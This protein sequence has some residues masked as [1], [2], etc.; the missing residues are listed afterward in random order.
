M[1]VAT[2]LTRPFSISRWRLATR[3]R[4]ERPS[5]KRKGAV[6]TAG[7]V[8]T[9]ALLLAAC[10]YVRFLGVSRYLWDNPTHDRNAHYLYSLK[11]ATDVR[12][13]QVL[14]LL[15]DLNE[16]RVW[17]PLHGVLAG[18]VLLAGGRDYRLA[19]LPSLAGWVLT[20]LFGFLVARRA[21]GRGGTLAGLIAALFIAAS[22]AHRAFATD[23]M[24]ESLG[25]AL[26]LVVLY[27]YLL[28]V[29]GQEDER[30]KGRCLGLALS[31]LFL[32]KYNYWLLVGLALAA[33]EFTARPRYFVQWAGD[34]LGSVPWRRWASAQLRHPLTYALAAVLLL[35]GVVSWHGDQPFTWGELRI[36]LYPPHNLLHLAY[37]LVF[38]RLTAWWWQTGR[39]RVRRLDDRVRQV[40][41]WH[42]CPLAVWFL[43]PKHPSYFLWYLSLAN[44]APEQP[45]D[46]LRGI[47]QYGAWLIE[48]YHCD[49]KW[50]MLSLG[51]CAA[52]L[53][54]WR[55]V[56]PGGRAVLLFVIIAAG[57]A[58]AHPNQKSRNLHSWMAA[59]WVMAG[60]GAAT[61]LY[62][63]RWPRLASW[64]GGALVTVLAGM[65]LPALLAAGHS[66][67]GGLHPASFSM[68]DA[69]D[70]YLP[71]LDHSRR[72]L[73]LTS[74]PLK[75]LAQWTF[76][77][78]YGRFA[79]LEEYWYGFGAPGEENR[80]G[81][82]QWLRT[83]DCETLVYCD[84]IASRDWA[85][86]GPECELH[87]ELRD[88][89][90]TQRA[91]RLIRQTDFPA[92]ACRI[93][94]WRR[95]P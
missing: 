49:P 84:R 65:Q 59:V 92:Y 93:Q 5:P 60:M 47:R 90:R 77:E 73:I 50:A 26:S 21:V 82:E 46:L 78:R 51:M 81:F 62:H 72:T 7:I 48:D 29:Q 32:E 57:L 83:T 23:I 39:R 53:M 25:A 11:L 6:W 55:R 89:V 18:A 44:A 66:P 79:G 20:V 35:V 80:R 68:L 12:N 8:F 28:A 14:Q 86:A 9:V 52:G 24:L 41:L 36:S 37:V 17:P 40:V 42:V 27:T 91:F 69:I 67:E 87:A 38:V 56:R 34:T 95:R 94:V 2:A 22:P 4:S 76:L 88:L 70:T 16:A 1:S 61:L 19:V 10:L 85:D 75:P 15:S 30:W 43:L 45:I 71:D 31:V 64:L 74:V 33:A 63:G 54:A 13:G 58:V 3:G